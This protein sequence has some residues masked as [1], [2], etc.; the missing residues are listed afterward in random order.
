[1]RMNEKR[2]KMIAAGHICLDIMP[3]IEGVSVDKVED[4]LKPGCLVHTGK[5]NVHIGGSV[6]NT[7]LALSALGADVA[8]MG[9]IGDDVWGNVITSQIEE[10]ASAGYMIRDENVSTS[11]SVVLAI[12][13]IDRMFLHHT[14]ANDSFCCEDL[15]EE[16]MRGAKLFHFGY[17]PLMKSIYSENGN[18]LVKIFDK[19]KGMGMITSLDMASIDANSGSGKVD[20]ISYLQN[21]LPKTDLFVPS[22]EELAFMIAPE[23]YEKWV[24]RAGGRDMTTVIRISEIRSLAEKS[25]DMG[26]KLVLIK[27]GAAGIYLATGGREKMSGLSSVLAD[28]AS[29]TDIR[30]FERSYK[31][32][33]V[34][35]ATGAG[36]TS[37]AAFLYTFMNGYGWKEC[38]Q[39][40]AA[41]GASCVEAYDAVSGLK[42]IPELQRRIQNGWEKNTINISD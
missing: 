30:A 3:E 28:D 39:L 23:I 12:P 8:L 13:G 33:K 35:S 10:Y 11:Y 2:I 31:P 7:G 42:S 1:M 32:Q 20:W 6:A 25:L 26:A 38:L 22:A 16:A 9:K 18:E 5:A 34:L 14:G 29:W 15:N 27:C 24:K 40:A 21:V 41:T 17:P 36:D 37:I 4:Y 19:A